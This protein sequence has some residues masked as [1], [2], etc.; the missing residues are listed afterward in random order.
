MELKCKKVFEHLCYVCGLHTPKTHQRDLTT[1]VKEKFFEKFSDHFEVLPLF[2]ENC[3]PRVVCKS[4]VNILFEKRKDRVS[5]L[6]RPMIWREPDLN[7]ERCYGCLMPSL[8]G[9]SWQNRFK[10][11]YPYRG[12]TTSSKAVW[13]EGIIVR[14]QSPCPSCQDSLPVDPSPIGPISSFE[15]SISQP[16]EPASLT[17]IPSIDSITSSIS[18][19]SGEF[20]EPPSVSSTQSETPILITQSVFNDMTRRLR[21]T[22]N[23]TEVLGSILRENHLLEK[24]VRTTHLRNDE[25]FVSKFAEKSYTWDGVLYKI[26]YLINLQGLFDLFGIEHNPTQW[27]LFIDGSTASLKVMLLHIGNIYPSIPIAYCRKLPE[28]YENMQEVLKL[29]GYDIHRWLVIADFKLINILTGHGPAQSK[30]PCFLCL[31]YKNSKVNHYQFVDWDLRPEFGDYDNVSYS[32]FKPPLVPPAKIL[33]PSLH[34]KLGLVSQLMKKICENPS[35]LEVLKNL[36]RKSESKIKLG[37]FTG[38]EVRVLFASSDLEKTLP[39]PE[40]HAFSA[41]KQVCSNFLGNKRASNYEDLIGDMMKKFEK[42]G[43]SV[44]LKMHVLLSHLDRFPPNC[45]DYSDEQ[46]ERSHQ[47]FLKIETQFLGK[48]MVNGLG[49]YCS[50]LIRETNPTLDRRQTSY[51]KRSFFYSPNN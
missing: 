6:V 16:R 12:T 41:L 33:F 50:S 3:T 15:S 4:C 18:Q 27:R 42:L 17:F 23:Q 13:K 47:D 21:L 2:D 44:T 36:F 35:S 25:E 19:S 26:A 39:D 46:G 14:E 37:V 30:Y 51:T 29:I 24:G 48:S 38:P 11:P 34:I 5:K 1:E 31:W 8:V 7:H 49:A 40:K 10:I 28:K 20:Y 45:G 32:S 43:I 22:F 9:S